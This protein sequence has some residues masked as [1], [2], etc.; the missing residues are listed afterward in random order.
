MSLWWLS[1][2]HGTEA[3]SSRKTLCPPGNARYRPKEQKLLSI[4]EARRP[5][6]WKGA[7]ELL[8]EWQERSW[9]EKTRGGWRGGKKD[10]FNREATKRREERGL[11]FHRKQ[12]LS[13]GREIH[14]Y[15]TSKTQ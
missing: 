10:V 7:T 3:H 9:A 12:P 5:G 14:S 11:Y 1:P 13:S 8:Q 15:P 6:A 4:A 2:A